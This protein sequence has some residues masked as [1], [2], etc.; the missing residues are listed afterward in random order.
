MAR[1]G[2]LGGLLHKLIETLG[3]GLGGWWILRVGQQHR[4]VVAEGG[5][6]GFEVERGEFQLG[7]GLELLAQVQLATG[8]AEAE[9]AVAR[10]LGT[11]ADAEQTK[12]KRLCKRLNQLWNQQNKH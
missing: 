8:V 1:D 9:D 4:H 12:Q 11:K 2:V 6:G 3:D 10:F 7:Y 5:H